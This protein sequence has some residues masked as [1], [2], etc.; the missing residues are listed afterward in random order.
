M[1][2]SVAVRGVGVGEECRGVLVLRR[3]L[4]SKD[5]REIGREFQLADASLENLSTRLTE[6]E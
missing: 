1:P 5:Q 2:A 6:L 3:R 4:L